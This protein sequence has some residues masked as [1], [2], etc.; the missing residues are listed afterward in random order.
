[1]GEVV[2]HHGS[3]T[4]DFEP[5]GPPLE[6]NEVR[7]ILFNARRLLTVRGCEEAVALLDSAPFQII[8]AT[9]HFNDPFHIL[10]AKVPLT[11]YET[12]RLAQQANRQPALELA[13]AISEAD[14][15]YIRF[16]AVGLVLADLEKWDV[17]LCHASEDKATIAGPLATHLKNVGI[18]CWYDDAEIGWGDSIVTQV[19]EGLN[20]ARY[21]AVVVT[22]AF[23]GKGWSQKELRT[24]LTLEI[25]GGRNLVL[26]LLAGEPGELLAALPFLKEKRYLIWTGKPD[27][28]EQELRVL[29]RRAPQ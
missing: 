8:P 14:G 6:E 7:R 17:F 11:E 21:V 19:Q 28:V 29:L 9:N 1:M 26:P 22:Q 16:I 12:F 24:A 13:E 15:P 27:V 10:Y 2:L 18:T 23:L 20:R 5:V 25:E 4:L 3:G